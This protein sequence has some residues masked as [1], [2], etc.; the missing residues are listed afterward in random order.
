MA[1]NV[2]YDVVFDA[3]ENSY[4]IQRSGVAL[5]TKTPMS[6]NNQ[7]RISG[8]IYNRPST[9]TFETRGTASGGMVNLINSRGS[10]A[11]VTTTITGKTHVQFNML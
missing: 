1:E 7:V 8:V 11:T 3:D 4:T 5:E 6:F 9:I 10:T 2:A